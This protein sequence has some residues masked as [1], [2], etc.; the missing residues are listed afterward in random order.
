[1]CTMPTRTRN[2]RLKRLFG[3]ANE[4]FV[5]SLAPREKNLYFRVGDMTRVITI[6]LLI[7]RVYVRVLHCFI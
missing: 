3:D 7:A 1:M 4:Y 2:I 5:I 6:S